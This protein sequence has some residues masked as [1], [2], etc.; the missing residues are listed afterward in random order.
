MGAIA[1][2]LPKMMYEDCRKEEP[3]V[4][5]ACENFGKICGSLTMGY[6]RDM[7]KTR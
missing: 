3:E 6:V 7:L 2:V 5:T 4:V 1:K